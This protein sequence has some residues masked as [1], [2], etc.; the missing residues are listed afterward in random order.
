MRTDTAET[1]E[2]WLPVLAVRKVAEDTYQVD[3]SLRDGIFPF[4]PGQYMQVT[5]QELLFPDPKGRSRFFTIV[6]DPADNK[7]ASV[8]FRDTGSGFK[9]TLISGSRDI[10]L[11]LRGPY[12]SF[13]LPER[14]DRQLILIGGGVGIAPFL[15]MARYA[16]SADYG[17]RIR[18]LQANTRKSRAA[19]LSE[20]TRLAK[21]HPSFEFL[22]TYDPITPEVLMKLDQYDAAWFIC[23]PP[24]MVTETRTMLAFAGINMDNVFYE[25]FEGYL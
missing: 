18:L 21:L 9:R 3:F 7:R 1:Q 22:E 6:A 15:T 16:L 13:H 17:Y 24:R 5:V 23:G 11:S 25:D 4:Q 20:F 8:V 2:V 10:R 12:G 19:Y 14:S